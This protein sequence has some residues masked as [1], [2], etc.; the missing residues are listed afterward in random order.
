MDLQDTVV[1]P[2]AHAGRAAKG[3]RPLGLQHHADALADAYD[4]VLVECGPANAESVARLSRNGE[5]EIILS[6][7]KPDEQELVEIMAA[8]EKVGYSDLVLMSGR[9]AHTQVQ[10][11]SAA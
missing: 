7:P 9:S 1:E 2:A 4:L 10:K 8:F 3:R 5:H 6:A 11:R